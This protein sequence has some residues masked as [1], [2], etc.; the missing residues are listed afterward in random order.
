MNYITQSTDG[1]SL[2]QIIN[3]AFVTAYFPCD[4]FIEP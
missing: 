4:N 3:A 2:F 1:L